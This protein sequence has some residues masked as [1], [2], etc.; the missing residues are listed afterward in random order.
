[1]GP[2]TPDLPVPLYAVQ[3]GKLHA[4]GVSEGEREGAFVTELLATPVGSDLSRGGTAK[5]QGLTQKSA[6][7][8]GPAAGGPSGL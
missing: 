5:L 4:G 8:I 7:V 1:M 6:H 3:A 2:E